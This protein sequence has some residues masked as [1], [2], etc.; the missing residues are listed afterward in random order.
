MDSSIFNTLTSSDNPVVAIL[1]G[2][3]VILSGVV[4]YQWRYT[5]GSTVPKWIW[6]SLVGKIDTIAEGQKTIGIILDERL[7][8]N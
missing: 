4:V 2:L 6:D 5:M 3:V 8:R 7:K 1:A